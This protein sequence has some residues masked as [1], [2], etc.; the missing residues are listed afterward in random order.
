ME[1]EKAMSK[2][3]ENI[4]SLTERINK[5]GY[6]DH[7]D[8][9]DRLKENKDW[10]VRAELAVL[11][12]DHIND[13]SKQVLMNLLDDR[14]YLVQVEAIDSLSSVTD[15]DV[16]EKVRKCMISR[17]PLVR[18]Y[19]YRWLCETQEE[20][21]KLL[22]ELHLVHE[23]D[24]WARNMLYVGLA[25]IG[26]ETVVRSLLR[27]YRRCNYLNRCAIAN[28]LADIFDDL[29]R[30]DQKKIRDFVET[31]KNPEI[32]VAEAEAF[33][34]LKQVCENAA[35]EGRYEYTEE[36]SNKWFEWNLKSK[37]FLNNAV[38]EKR[39]YPISEEHSHCEFCWDKFSGEEGDLKSGYYE[40]KTRSW[41]CDSCYNIYKD[42]FHWKVQG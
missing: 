6:Q 9:I 13:H 14:S 18:G 26:D 41:V 42:F 12:A 32:S 25:Q 39:T 11:L 34:R 29:S 35:G 24:I 16:A 23:K 27:S 31:Y 19:A 22:Q 10:Y 3:K 21:Q 2:R 1:R 30:T 37:T 36:E 17:H 40:C 28:G 5:T 8:E 20:P 4:D 38:F 15:H 33:E 7:I